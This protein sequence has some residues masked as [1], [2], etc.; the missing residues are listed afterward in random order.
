MFAYD[1][2][3]V[4][5]N[6]NLYCT[7][8]EIDE[9][10]SQEL[11]LLLDRWEAGD[12]HPLDVLL[13][14]GYIV[15]VETSH[16]FRY[17]YYQKDTFAASL[18]EDTLN[19]ARLE[20]VDLEAHRQENLN[21][22]ITE[23]TPSIKPMMLDSARHAEIIPIIESLRQK[24]MGLE[25]SSWEAAFAIHEILYTETPDPNSPWTR[26]PLRDV[27]DKID[28]EIDYI[29]RNEKKEARD[30]LDRLKPQTE[31]ELKVVLASSFAVARKK[32]QEAADNPNKEARD[33]GMYRRPRLTQF[34]YDDLPKWQKEEKVAYAPPMAYP[35]GLLCHQILIEPTGT[36]TIT[37]GGGEP[38]HCWVKT[39]IGRITT[40]AISL[41]PVDPAHLE[42][43]ADT[44]MEALDVLDYIPEAYDGDENN[45]VAS[46]Y[47]SVKDDKVTLWAKLDLDDLWSLYYILEPIIE[48]NAQ[49]ATAMNMARFSEERGGI[50]TPDP[51]TYNDFNAEHVLMHKAGSL[52]Q[53]TDKETLGIALRDIFTELALGKIDEAQFSLQIGVIA[54]H[55]LTGQMQDPARQLTTYAQMIADQRAQEGAL[56]TYDAALKDR[57][58]HLIRLSLGLDDTSEEP[59]HRALMR[60]IHQAAPKL[61]E[62]FRKQ[63][64][65]TDRTR[66]ASLAQQSAENERSW[67]NR[68]F[69]SLLD[70]QNDEANF[71]QHLTNALT[72]RNKRTI[73]QMGIDEQIEQRGEKKTLPAFTG[74]LVRRESDVETF[75]DGIH[76]LGNGYYYRTK[77]KGSLAPRKELPKALE[78]FIPKNDPRTAAI[79]S[80]PHILK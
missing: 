25:F 80:L 77:T 63:T 64:E 31:D 43:L 60:T 78:P 12:L 61:K 68:D 5:D 51:D 32:K 23:L 35:E 65:S 52:T 59:L 13:E 37:L 10:Q 47:A 54:D 3:K 46:K 70:E 50:L 24:I 56:I 22:A 58:Q 21:A 49:I 14:C 38:D 30:T 73:G 8:E 27:K 67:R 42:I 16:T 45:S 62:Q 36:K 48:P 29:R 75:I 1:R 26:T 53:G 66:L 6:K 4:R 74:N 69:R 40:Y 79:F 15:G 19:Q 34:Y 39:D 2:Y 7:P 18:R 9:R 33:Y 28:Q 44:V 11:L 20:K 41:I 17:R 55:T 71:L 72:G 76:D 57:A